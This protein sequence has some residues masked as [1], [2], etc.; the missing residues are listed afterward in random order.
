MN[1][2]ET[3]YAKGSTGFSGKFETTL[4]GANGFNGLFTGPQASELIGNFAFPYTS[5]L[6]GK[7]YEAGGA[8]I[9]KK[10]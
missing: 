8:F 4:S 10:P 1:F 3:V 6:D 5:A 2:V 9:A 7:N